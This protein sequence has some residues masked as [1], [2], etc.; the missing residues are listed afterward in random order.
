VLVRLISSQ[1][2]QHG[3]RLVGV[4]SVNPQPWPFTNHSVSLPHAPSLSVC[5]FLWVCIVCVCFLLYRFFYLLC[6]RCVF[7]VW[8]C[9]HNH[10][11][12]LFLLFLQENRQLC[13]GAYWCTHTP[14]N[15]MFHLYLHFSKSCVC[16]YKHVYAFPSSSI[17]VHV[18]CHLHMYCLCYVLYLYP[19]F[20]LLSSLSETW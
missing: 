14:V 6:A 4:P 12:V 20:C 5:L 9:I 10:L 7:W 15:M 18:Y 8:F 16:L 19:C 17:F 11:F 13:H 1:S 2:H 3:S